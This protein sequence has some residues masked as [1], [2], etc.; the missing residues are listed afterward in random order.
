MDR[1]SEIRHL[2]KSVA[3][4]D[5]K[6]DAFHLMEV[7]GIEEDT[8]RAKLGDLEI[9]EIRLSS[10]FKGA[11]NGI[12]IIP[13]IGSIILVADLSMGELRDLVAIA[14]SEI[15]SI[16]IR[17][18]DTTI[19]HDKDTVRIETGKN[20]FYMDKESTSFSLGESNVRIESGLIRLNSG[21]NEGLTKVKEVT[22]RLNEI[23]RDINTLKDLWNGW[24]PVNTTL[25]PDATFL[26]STMAAWA[27][28]RLTETSQ[29][30]IENTKVTH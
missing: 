28:A 18:E 21:T 30:S 13:E 29:A 7:T 23:E 11:E 27:V 10:I 17:K 9:P 14:Y 24:Q 5:Q 25:E 8:C 19:Y 2:I 26:H 1:L 20:T 16:R 6:P 15:Q 22:A 12:L 4:T 3:G